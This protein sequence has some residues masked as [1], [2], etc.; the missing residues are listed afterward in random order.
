[1]FRLNAPMAIF[2]A[3]ALYLLSLAGSYFGGVYLGS[4]LVLLAIVSAMWLQSILTIFRLRFQEDESLTHPAKG[5]EFTYRV[6]VFGEMPLPSSPCRAVFSGVGTSGRQTLTEKRFI[7]DPKEGMRWEF[8]ITCP[9]RGIY[10][11]GLTEIQIEDTLGTGSVSIEGPARTVYVY[12]RQ[13]ELKNCRVIPAGNTLATADAGVG[14]E[15]DVTRFSGLREYRFGESVRHLDWKRTTATGVP[16][17][18]EYETTSVPGLS[19]YIDSRIKTTGDDSHRGWED[20]ALEAAI[21]IARFSIKRGVSVRIRY[22]EI[23]ILM[24]PGDDVSFKNLL[25]G[26]LTMNFGIPL[27]V[28]EGERLATAALCESAADLFDID[29]A[30]GLVDTGKYVAIA[31]HLDEPVFRFLETAQFGIPPTAVIVRDALDEK[32]LM[33]L[34]AYTNHWHEGQGEIVAIRSAE[35]LEAAP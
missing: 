34:S 9:Y 10:T 8:P 16:R 22:N 20:T 13:I 17:L 24:E 27:N 2:V 11:I 7:T 6:S 28:P 19:I 1:M 3:A 32:E 4:F 30:A 12:P 14:S 33:L 26:T 21:A 35:D 31:R 25:E 29:T 23:N 18:R 15:E 5:Q